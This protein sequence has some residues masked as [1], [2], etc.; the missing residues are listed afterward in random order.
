[1]AFVDVALAV[2][3]YI[4]A[5]ALGATAA[6]MIGGAAIGAGAGGIYSGLTGGNIGQGMLGGAALGA[7]G[8]GLGMAFA[9]EVAAGAAPGVVA[10]AAVSAPVGTLGSGYV[11]GTGTGLTGAGLGATETAA[12]GTLGSNYVAPS[13][14]GALGTGEAG[15]GVGSGYVAGPGTGLTGTGLNQLGA[16]K[17]LLDYLPSAKQAGL[18][19]GAS[20]L[21]K[22][23]G[24]QNTI[25]PQAAQEVPEALRYSFNRNT[26]QPANAPYYGTPQPNYPNSPEAKRLIGY[27]EGGSVSLIEEL[28]GKA[29]PNPV[30]EGLRYSFDRNTYQ[31]AVSPYHETSQSSGSE[32]KR[33]VGYAAGGITNAAPYDMALG[34]PAPNI[35]FANP[36]Q[37]MMGT[38]QY[39]MATD[40]TNGNIAQRNMAKGGI[41]S[42]AGGG[43]PI[44]LHGTADISGQG[45][46]NGYSAAGSGGG[47]QGGY[48]GGMPDRF[49][50]TG[51]NTTQQP[52]PFPAGH[53]LERNQALIGPMPERPPGFQIGQQQF[54]QVQVA[55]QPMQQP[56]GCMPQMRFPPPIQAS[57][58]DYQLQNQGML[59]EPMQAE[60]QQQYPVGAKLEGYAVGGVTKAAP[61]A[62]TA[63]TVRTAPTAKTGSA[64][65]VNAINQYITL[66]KTSPEGLT[67]VTNAATAGDYN[68]NYA[69]NSLKSPDVQMAKGGIMRG[70]LGGYSDGGRMLKG[71]GDG[72]SDDIPATI[73]HKQPARLADSEFVIPADVVSHL[74]NGSSDAGAKKLYSM[75]DNVRKARTG[76]KK[77]GKK[78]NP[79]KFM[80]A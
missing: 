41:A 34:G 36:A 79:N 31:P 62:R 26:Y 23:L 76:T 52:Q 66:A 53:P 64:H 11:T 6:T 7:G 61:T 18:G 70:D 45:N 69:L 59:G 50:T 35:N 10:P 49:N 15:V 48:G 33:L 39:S 54:P 75:M 21:A 22:N 17:S 3:T 27:E 1:M 12:A 28:L 44:E 8:A 55:Q 20:Y 30:P 25:N 29:T 57:A 38:S 43:V 46:D 4:G 9:P 19:L 2:G 77:Q 14:I 73:G 5:D 72:M 78:I 56:V 47:Q 13:A 80:P 71:P 40:P 67:S 60:Q 58:Q 37:S 24:K 51:G 16:T 74:G 63:P 68:A 42:F 32:A 65:N